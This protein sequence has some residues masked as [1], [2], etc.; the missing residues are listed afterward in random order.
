MKSAFPR[1]SRPRIASPRILITRLS[2]IGDCVQTL[3]VATALREHFPN[4]FIAWASEPAGAPLV[5]SHPAVD[6]VVDVPKHMLLSPAGVSRVRRSLR[7]LHFDLVIDPQSLTKSSAV[8][9]LSGAKRRIGFARP[10]AREVSPL[11]NTELVK[12]TQPHMVDRYLEMLRPLGVTNPRVQFNLRIGSRARQAVAPFVRRRELSGGFA[13]LN[14]GAGWDSKR[15]PA[16]RFAQV[17]QRLSRDHGLISVITWAGQ[18]EQTWAAD[19]YSRAGGHAIVAPKTNLM[20]LAALL[21]E[22]SFVVASDTGP[23][24]LA[25]AMGAPCV[26]L[27]GSTRR[28]VCGPYGAANIALQEAY[29]A[30]YGR[31]R[32]G[33]SNWAVA[34]ITV[35][36]VVEACGGLIRARS[37]RHR[38]AA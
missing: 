36:M 22:A 29:D 35:E 20:E 17:A 31:K 23:L 12:S 19:I 2:A 7:E 34:R 26:G 33:A 14:V 25:A 6:H 32:P 24:H 15:W 21:Q 9:W 27:Y 13:V 28:E 4:A 3:P 38:L 18:R 10:T 1:S 16:E 8:G 11:L 5:A 37:H 30:S